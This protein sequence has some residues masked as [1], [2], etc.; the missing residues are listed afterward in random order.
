M[1][2][3][4]YS[5]SRKPSNPV[6]CGVGSSL[7]SLAR[8][9]GTL[10]GQGLLSETWRKLTDGTGGRNPTFNGARLAPVPQLTPDPQQG[11]FPWA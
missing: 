5:E 8:V 6:S 11:Q 7:L 4:N 1:L 2:S 3:A 10:V 9:I